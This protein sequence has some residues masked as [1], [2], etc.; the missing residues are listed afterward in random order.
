MGLIDIF[1]EYAD[2]YALRRAYN[3]GVISDDRISDTESDIILECDKTKKILI[4]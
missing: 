1:D 3:A 4:T 2:T